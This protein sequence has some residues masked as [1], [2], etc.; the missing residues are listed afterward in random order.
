MEK[1]EDDEIAVKS[2]AQKKREKKQRAK[3]RKREQAALEKSSGCHKTGSVAAVQSDT[4]HPVK[5][6]SKKTEDIDDIFAT[7]KRK[8]PSEHGRKGDDNKP[9]KQKAPQLDDDEIDFSDARGNKK[10]S[11][12]CSSVGTLYAHTLPERKLVDGLRVYTE[13]ELGMNAEG[14]G[15]HGELTC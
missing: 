5:S 1:S 14:G 9:R 2:K 4:S 6:A 3:Q 7:A 15:E 12:A 8:V 13:E 11:E 10:K